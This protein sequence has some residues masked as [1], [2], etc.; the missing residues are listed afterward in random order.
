MLWI[1][2][3]L[4]RNVPL[5]VLF[6]ISMQN[7]KYW[8]LSKALHGHTSSIETLQKTNTLYLDFSIL[9]ASLKLEFLN[10]YKHRI[11]K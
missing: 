5:A 10:N 6:E 1:I 8:A 9:P 2:E 7:I 11:T 3:E 4:Q